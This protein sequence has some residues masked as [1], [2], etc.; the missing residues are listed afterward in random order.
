MQQYIVCAGKWTENHPADKIVSTQV[1]L[2][3]NY[4][5]AYIKTMLQH[6]LF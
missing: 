3:H 5:Q 1:D 6:S 2:D 4:I